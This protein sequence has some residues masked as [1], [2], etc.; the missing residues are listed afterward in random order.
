MFI[1]QEILSLIENNRFRSSQPRQ[2]Q[3]RYNNLFKN[4]NTIKKELR[5]SQV[6]LLIKILFSQPKR[7]IH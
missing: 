7:N 3:E 5:K 2:A 1:S 6:T 4:T